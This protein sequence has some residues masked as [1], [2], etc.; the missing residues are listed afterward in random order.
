MRRFRRCA[1][2]SGTNP[3]SLKLISTN[4]RNPTSKHHHQ[5][6]VQLQFAQDVMMS[7]FPLSLIDIAP[8]FNSPDALQFSRSRTDMSL[9]IPLAEFGIFEIPLA[10]NQCISKNR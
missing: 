5:K 7:P 10:N 1:R 9:V 2:W 3:N 4:A 8:A 6:I